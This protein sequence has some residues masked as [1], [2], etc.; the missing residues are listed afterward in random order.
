[1]IKNTLSAELHGIALFIGHLK[2]LFLIMCRRGGLALLQE[3]PHTGGMKPLG[4]AAIH[5]LDQVPVPKP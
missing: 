1:L 5:V 4:S 3:E 2:L